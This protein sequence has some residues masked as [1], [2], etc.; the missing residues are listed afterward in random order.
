MARP[1][2]P[3]TWQRALPHP[4]PLRCGAAFLG[5][6]Y[7]NP[8][9]ECGPL[10]QRPVHSKRKG[11]SQPPAAV[12]TFCPQSARDLRNRRTFIVTQTPS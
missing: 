12:P 10:A 8:A 9:N 5:H 1:L 6:L 7:D 3:A 4:L 11:G 2:S